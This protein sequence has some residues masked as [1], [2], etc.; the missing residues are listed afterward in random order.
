MRVSKLKQIIC[1]IALGVVTITQAHAIMIAGFNFDDNAFADTAGNADTGFS[2]LGGATSLDD[3]LTGSDTSTGISYFGSLP[4]SVDIGFTDNLIV[5]GIGN[6]LMIFEFGN[7]QDSLDLTIGG[8]S[9]NTGLSTVTAFGSGLGSF[10][11][12]YWSMD[13]SD[14]GMAFGATVS[15][16]TLSNFDADGNGTSA[17]PSVIAALNSA[18][19]P[20]PTTFTLMGLG[21]VGL[22]LARKRI[23]LT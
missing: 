22:G 1:G 19:V 23:R 6:D 9:I 16:L 13:L 5:N 12:Y 10:P 20:E 2:L 21:L 8:S 7:A 14:F 11:I 18:S 15:A 17:T 3:A 4:G